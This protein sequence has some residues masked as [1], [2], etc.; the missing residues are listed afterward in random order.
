MDGDAV[1]D[2]GERVHDF[3]LPP[4]HHK[5]LPTDASDHSFEAISMGEEGAVERGWVWGEAVFGLRG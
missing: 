2:A 3:G 4:R 1:G 5:G